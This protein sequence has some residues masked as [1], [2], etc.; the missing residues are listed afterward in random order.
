MQGLICQD[1]CAFV[2][3]WAVELLRRVEKATEEALAFHGTTTTSTRQLLGSRLGAT[4]M[5]ITSLQLPSQIRGHTPARNGRARTRSRATPLSCKHNQ[6]TI[7]QVASRTSRRSTL[8]Y[9]SSAFFAMFLVAE[10]AEARTSRQENKR[11]VMEKLEKVREEALGSK[12]KKE[13]TSKESVANLLMPP[14]L[15]DAYI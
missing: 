7:V 15:V 14:T 1:K 3:Q 8:A 5:A 4:T 13:D 2:L 12:E 6:S 11:K 10:H 9:I